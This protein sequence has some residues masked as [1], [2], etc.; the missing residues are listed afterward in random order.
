MTELEII[1]YQP[2]YH[3]KTEAEVREILGNK[4]YDRFVHKEMR[5][6]LIFRGCDVGGMGRWP[7]ARCVRELIERDRIDGI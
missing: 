4:D 1:T 3:C 7:K 2:N 6:V 5:R